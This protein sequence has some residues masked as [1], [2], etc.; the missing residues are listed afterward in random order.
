[1][2]IPTSSSTPPTITGG[3][4]CWR[5]LPKTTPLAPKWD[6]NDEATYRRMCSYLRYALRELSGIRWV[7]HDKWTPSAEKA[8]TN[9]MHRL[10]KLYRRAKHQQITWDDK[11]LRHQERYSTYAEEAFTEGAALTLS[12]E[13]DI[14]TYAEY[15]NHRQFLRK[16][17][18]L[19]ELV[20]T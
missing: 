5:S 14:S 2:K 3:G 20:T 18:I 4:S 15:V 6:E 11:N 10:R 9:A 12:K 7:E 19:H 1:M 17:H 16:L 13:T 8:L